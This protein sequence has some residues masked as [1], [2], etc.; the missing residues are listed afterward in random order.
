[1]GTLLGPESHNITLH[2]NLYA[3]NGNR[4]PLVGAYDAT[5]IINNVVYNWQW[6]GTQFQHY[7]GVGGQ[8]G[9]IVAN[10]Y[11]AGNAGQFEYGI[12][13]SDS[14]SPSKF[15]VHNNI[16]PTRTSQS[17]D[18]WA[19]VYGGSSLRSN[20]PTFTPT[21]VTTDEVFANY[22][23]VLAKA[24]AR[25][26]DRDSV[27]IRVVNSVLNGTGNLIDSQDDVGGWPALAENHVTLTVPSN[28]HGDDDGDGY[29][30]LEEWLNGY[31]NLVT[32]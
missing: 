10:Y 1:M 5:E 24:G 11:K 16:G 13:L 9:N 4:N 20:T 18:D 21:G 3:H 29:T 12:S 25:S 32:A 19:I 7:S 30:N 31:E 6:N 8:Y 27:D 23:N 26:A 15:Y 14:T 28:P 17:Q 2:H 22:T